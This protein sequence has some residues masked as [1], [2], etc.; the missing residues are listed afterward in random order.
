MSEWK[1]VIFSAECD[2]WG[3]CPV[4]ETDYS[5]CE[6]PGPTMDDEYE[7][8]IHEGYLQARRLE[9]SSDAATEKDAG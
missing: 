8:R 2:E 9:E 4:C 6:C 7:Y 5:E 3:N 1:R